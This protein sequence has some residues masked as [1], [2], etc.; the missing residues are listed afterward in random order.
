M[1][2]SQS[3]DALEAAVG[4][5]FC[6]DCQK[7]IP[8]SEF[9]S[10]PRIFK[11]RPHFLEWRRTLVSATPVKRSLNR[12]RIESH[13]DLAIFGQKPMSIGSDEIRALLTPEQLLDSSNVSIVP[14]DPREPLSMSNCAV[15]T[16]DQRRQILSRWKK[17]HDADAY[18]DAFEIMTEKPQLC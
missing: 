13:Q 11:C 18:I 9:M 5:R 15:I 7:L 8:L 16:T 2:R 17:T 1:N 12:I 3:S 6:F 10:G 14:L 4:L